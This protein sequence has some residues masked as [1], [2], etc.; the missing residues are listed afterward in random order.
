MTAKLSAV[1][2]WRDWRKPSTAERFHSLLH[3]LQRNTHDLGHGDLY[4]QV[5][6]GQFIFTAIPPKGKAYADPLGVKVEAIN[7]PTTDDPTVRIHDLIDLMREVNA[8]TVVDKE[9]P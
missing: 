5:R 6:D 8:H 2:G 4:L 3:T 1:P 9:A 7:V